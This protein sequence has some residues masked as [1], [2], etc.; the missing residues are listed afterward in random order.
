MAQALMYGLG[1][2]AQ[3]MNPGRR[4]LPESA[5]EL[6]DRDAVSTEQVESC[7]AL[8][9]KDLT[10]TALAG[11]P[12]PA[13]IRSYV[14]QCMRFMT[15]KSDMSEPEWF[16]AVSLLD[17][18]FLKVTGSIAMIPATCI[19]AVRLVRK[20]NLSART[21]RAKDRHRPLAASRWTLGH[22]EHFDYLSLAR[23]ISGDMAADMAMSGTKIPEITEAILDSHELEICKAV[24][25]RIDVMTIERWIWLFSTRLNSLTGSGYRM[26]MTKVM[27]MAQ[28]LVMHKSASHQFSHHNLALGVFFIGLGSAHLIPR[29]V[30][31]ALAAGMDAGFVLHDRESEGT[32]T[33]ER[34]SLMINIV[35]SVTC[36][37]LH[38]LQQAA[39]SVMQGLLAAQCSQRGA[40]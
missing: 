3:A 7:R 23:R 17:T 4:S 40:G 20:F 21:R 9:Q 8:E 14:L 15:L 32:H 19:C 34:A 37:E 31:L 29:D 25:W 2:D 11:P 6:W 38:V 33:H 1:A 22:A 36:C 35:E 28:K 16:Q 10:P 26:N 39:R 12:L 27:L 24:N 18:Y 13:R 30:F 5:L